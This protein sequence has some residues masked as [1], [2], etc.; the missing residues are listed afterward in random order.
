[1]PNASPG[2]GYTTVN[3]DTVSH[4]MV[5]HIQWQGLTGTT[6]ASHIH[7]PTATPFS[8]TAGV[9]TQTPYFQDFPIGVTAG[10]YDHEFNTLASATW[11]SS[12]ISANGGTPAGA[13]AAMAA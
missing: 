10:T 1:P 7:A 8:G 11:N 9:A 2:I 12:Y 6:T 4:S 5:I 13:E 3:F